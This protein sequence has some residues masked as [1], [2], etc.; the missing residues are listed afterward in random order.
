MKGRFAGFAVLT[1]L[2]LLLTNEGAEALG[3]HANRHVRHGS[4]G[5]SSYITHSQGYRHGDGWYVHDADKLPI[6]S[7]VWWQQM[8]REG[9]VRN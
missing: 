2:V 8:L 9:R 7:Q 6:G 5:Q 1:A 4:P 3:R